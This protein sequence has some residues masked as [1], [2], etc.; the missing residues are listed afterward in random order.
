MT[1]MTKNLCKDKVDITDYVEN[2]KVGSTVKDRLRIAIDNIKGGI[3]KDDNCKI[4]RRLVEVLWK[5][6]FMSEEEALTI[7][8]YARGEEK[9][10]KEAEKKERAGLTGFL[11]NLRA[12]LR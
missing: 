1:D 6:K 12:K 5:Y 8:N 9:R 4:L 7:I 11:R 2:L 3:G 10:C